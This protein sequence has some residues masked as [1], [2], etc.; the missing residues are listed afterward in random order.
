MEQLMDLEISGGCTQS[1]FPSVEKI[2]FG[3]TRVQK[4][5]SRIAGKKVGSKFRSIM[6]W[7]FCEVIGPPVWSHCMEYYH[8]D[9]EP[10]RELYSVEK[11]RLYEAKLLAAARLLDRDYTDFDFIRQRPLKE[12]WASFIYAIQ[13]V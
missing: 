4:N 6:D 8:S 3:S 5:L 11:L 9:G 7:F 2:M 10:A 13:A 12:T 1:V